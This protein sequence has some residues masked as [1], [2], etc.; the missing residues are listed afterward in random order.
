M[1]GKISDDADAPITDTMK[2]AA[3]DGG[4]NKAPFGT[5]FKA[6]LKDYFDDLYLHSNGTAAKAE[7]L[8]TARNFD[9]QSFD[10]SADIEV[11]A[12]GTHAATRKTTPVDADELPL[13]DSAAS[14]ILKKLTWA[15]LKATLQTYFDS[16]Y[17][18]AAVTT[19][20]APTPTSSAGTGMAA[21]ATVRAVSITDKLVHLHV[22][23]FVSAGG[24]GTTSALLQVDLPFSVRAADQFLVGGERALTG[25]MAIGIIGASSNT[26]LITYAS[27]SGLIATG[28]HVVV[29]G[30]VER[31]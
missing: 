30:V 29:E 27:G 9:G 21:T 26:V 4:V 8:A 10:G 2:F 23:V 20:T 31:A 25:S 22:D 19:T 5:R 14:N 6:Y 28:A 24:S 11:I 15:D 3:E 1:T 12:P 17:L 16:L 18:P 7:I 13:V